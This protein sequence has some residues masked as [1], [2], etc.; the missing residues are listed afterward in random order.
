MPLALGPRVI[1]AELRLIKLT[2]Q[3]EGFPLMRPHI[4]N[5]SLPQHSR[6]FFV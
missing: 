1:S 5:E 6:W 2:Q 4:Q 3:L